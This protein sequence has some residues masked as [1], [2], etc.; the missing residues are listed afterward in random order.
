[1][2]C[3]VEMKGI[4]IGDYRKAL[5]EECEICSYNIVMVV[6]RGKRSDVYNMLKQL[7]CCTIGIPIQVIHLFQIC[8]KFF[9]FFVNICLSFRVS[10]V[11]TDTILKKSGKSIPT[12]VMIQMAAKLGAEPWRISGSP[13]PTEGKVVQ[14]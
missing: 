8:P 14:I 3:S 13:L 1:M 5:Q 7:A 9:F 4:S 2:N 6:C 10:Q 11:I 12:K